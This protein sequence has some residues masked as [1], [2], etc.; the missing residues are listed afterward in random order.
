LVVGA[1]QLVGLGLVG[2][3]ACVPL[4]LL[5]PLLERCLAHLHLP[6]TL[7][8]L[9]F[10]V[11]VYGVL[12]C[13]QVALVRCILPLPPPGSYPLHSFPALRWWLQCRLLR[14]VDRCYMG[15]LQGTPLHHWWLRA[16]GCKLGQDVRG[17]QG[18][19]II[20]DPDLVTIGDCAA[21]GPSV[22]LVGSVVRDGMLHRGTISVGGGGVLGA[23][24][25]MLPN[26]RTQ[27]HV[28]LQVGSVVQ[29]G[30]SLGGG[31]GVYTGHPAAFL[32]PHT[33]EPTLSE[34]RQGAVFAVGEAL[35]RCL[36][37]Q[38]L[39]VLAAALAYEPMTR[40]LDTLH[41]FPFLALCKWPQGRL[42]FCLLA[43]LGPL[44]LLCLPLLLGAMTLRFRV[45]SC[46]DRMLAT[47]AGQI[48]AGAVSATQIRQQLYT[49]QGL[50]ALRSL[51]P[52]NMQLLGAAGSE[53]L[54]LVMPGR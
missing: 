34:P 32:R 44:P 11:H 54:R 6:S 29:E 41:V 15:H 39:A 30:Q 45:L 2:M 38:G 10:F 24:V 4:L 52:S 17:L 16:L 49:E 25:V 37:P 33:T 51:L 7:A 42:L 19:A 23:G 5:Y 31:S 12:L 21:L 26:S 20:A 3:A 47:V 8:L 13:L 9:P 53:G 18:G 22:R 28:T 27:A 50:Q 1:L 43:L 36:L 40:L 48:G 46:D 35:L 14:L